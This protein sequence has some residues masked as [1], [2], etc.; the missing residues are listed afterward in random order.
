MAGFKFFQDKQHQWRWKLL[1][2]EGRIVADSAEGYHHQTDCRHG[3]DLFTHHSPQTAARVVANPTRENSGRGYDWECFPDVDGKWRWHFQAANNRIIADSGNHAAETEQQA[4]ALVERVKALLL[5]LAGQPHP[6]TFN[7]TVI[8]GG[9]PV[10]VA[11][12]AQ[13]LLEEVAREA[14]KISGNTARPLADWTI[15]T[16][17]GQVLQLGRTVESYELTEATPLVMSLEAG[18]GGTC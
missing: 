17:E 15:K 13:Q 5:G 3:A 2:Q 18:V 8:V 6:T 11:V 9:T 12:I 14:L 10:V 4:L 1:N 16:R 7:L